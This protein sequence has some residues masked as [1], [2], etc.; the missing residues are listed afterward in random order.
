MNEKVVSL[1]LNALRA[2]DDQTVAALP[3]QLDAET[4]LFGRHGVLDSLGLAS[5]VVSVEQAI[6]DEFGLSVSLADQK[7]LSQSHSPYRTVGS[8]AE[9][10][11]RLIQPHA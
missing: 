1:I 8:L 6:E 4:P 5:L 2:L 7:A 9:Y 11:S 3:P 10:A